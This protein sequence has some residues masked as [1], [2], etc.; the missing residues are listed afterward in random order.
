MALGGSERHEKKKT[1]RKSRSDVEGEVRWN[2]LTE[3]KEK[4]RRLK[5]KR[6]R[7][8][9]DGG[10]VERLSD[11]RTT[12]RRKWREEEVVG[13]EQVEEEEND[14]QEK[15]VEMISVGDWQSAMV[16]SSTKDR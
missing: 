1:T 10:E 14:R 13:K 7:S 16:D 2:R 5:V 12:T 3:K 11:L 15:D 4:R 9:G 8:V 6:R